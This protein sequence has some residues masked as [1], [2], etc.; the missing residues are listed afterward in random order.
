MTDINKRVVSVI[1]E[2][3]K[4]EETHGFFRLDP[5]SSIIVSED[6]IPI[7]QHLQEIIHRET[8]FLPSLSHAGSTLAWENNITLNTEYVPAL[9]DD[10]YELKITPNDIYIKAFKLAGAFYGVQ[11]LRQLI[12]DGADNARVVPAVEIQ[13]QPRFKWRGLMLDVGRHFYPT[14]FVKRFIDLLALHKMNVF[15]WHL[16]EDQGW[17]IEIKK[18]TKL[19]EIGSQRSDT[20]I[21]EDRNRFEGKPHWGYYTQ[22]EI[23]EIV[24]YAASRFITIVPEIE[25]PGHSLA[26]L[27]SY[28]DLGC[29]GGPYEVQTTWGIKK[30]VYCAGNEATFTFLEEVLTEVMKLFPSP[31]IHIGGD[32]VPKERWRNCPKCQSVIEKQGLKDEDEL[33]SYFIQRIEQF[34]NAR[35]RQLI[36]WDEILEGGL[37]PNAMVM[38]WRG[39]EGGIQAASTGHDAVMSPTSHCYFD[40]YQSKSPDEPPGP[41]W[42]GAYLPLETVYAYEPVPAALSAEHAGHIL[43]VQGN[44]WT[45]FIA[46]EDHVEYMAFPR[47]TALSEVAWS[48][49]EKRDY[50]DFMNRLQSFLPHLEKLDVKYRNPFDNFDK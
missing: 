8:G 25:M 37:A 39:I 20:Q 29:T 35:G 24:A 47:G 40:Y 10:G 38:S 27:A 7:G 22:E 18:Y 30:D 46:S 17:R 3:L 2:P 19:H 23:K 15:H 16:T 33:Q 4:V 1:P 42:E 9:G 26:A 36:G 31:V 6:L 41:Y 48:A 32:E 5:K 45:E 43:G 13:D 44:I 28:P 12:Q 11:T 50:Q 14:E 49:P 21:A 34:L